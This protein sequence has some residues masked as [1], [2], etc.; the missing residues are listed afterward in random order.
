MI[1]GG[2]GRGLRVRAR[3]LGAG[4]VSL[5][6]VG[7]VYCTNQLPSPACPEEPCEDA[8]VVIDQKPPG[9]LPPPAPPPWPDAGGRTPDAGGTVT[10]GPGPWPVDAVK[11][12][13]AAYALGTVQSA[14][15]D[16]GFNL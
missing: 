4:V 16:D 5:V 6:A 15:L 9:Q 12:Y 3:W 7:L 2:R 1:S 13:S 10:V 8:G 11:N 14:G